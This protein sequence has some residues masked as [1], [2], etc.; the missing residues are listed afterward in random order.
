MNAPRSAAGR[1]GTV[2]LAA[3]VE[4]LLTALVRQRR[5]V[6]DEEPGSLSTFQ[7]IA[8]G[9]LVDDGPMR[10]GALTEALRTTDA[11]ASRTVDVLATHKFA[12]RHHD[13]RDARRVL[14]AATDAGNRT[15][16]HRRRRLA[17]LLETLAAEM[18]T[19]SLAESGSCKS[20]PSPVPTRTR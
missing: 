9:A 3:A 18:D 2:A 6:G 15:V 5:V 12:E 1:S 8:L 20:S 4:Q 10:L 14:V 19:R 17:L 11:T 7:G 16:A 13:P